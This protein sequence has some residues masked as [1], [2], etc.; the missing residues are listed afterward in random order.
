MHDSQHTYE[1]YK[2]NTITQEHKM[3]NYTVTFTLSSFL[4]IGCCVFPVDNFPPGCCI[5]VTG[6][7]SAVLSHTPSGS[8][9]P[10]SIS[11]HLISAG[12]L[13][14]PSLSSSFYELTFSLSSL[15]AFLLD[16]VRLLPRFISLSVFRFSS[17]LYSSFLST[18][19]RWSNWTPFSLYG[20]LLLVDG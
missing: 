17:C 4:V 2:H 12:T 5:V 10:L 7:S 13:C 9:S 20:W 16:L 15:S 19:T 1:T 6:A 8:G 18:Q 11:F 14:L 3:Q